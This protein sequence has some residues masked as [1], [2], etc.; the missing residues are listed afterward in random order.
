VPENGPCSPG[1]SEETPSSHGPGIPDE[2]LKDCPLSDGPIYGCDHCRRNG[3][4][5]PSRYEFNHQPS[6]TQ[7][8]NK[9]S[10]RSAG[11]QPGMTDADGKYI[12]YPDAD[13]LSE[14][15]VRTILE[16]LGIKPDGDPVNE[17]FLR[18]RFGQGRRHTQYVRAEFREWPGEK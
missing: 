17:A 3:T 14:R 12:R 16:G 7:A 2:F 8:P 1:T 6:A 10:N 9:S 4:F 13:F 15:E 18:G 11:T 5:D